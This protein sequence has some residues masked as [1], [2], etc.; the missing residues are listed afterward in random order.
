MKR[1]VRIILNNDG[2][3]LQGTQVSE[4]INGTILNH[5]TTDTQK[6]GKKVFIPW[7]SIKYMIIEPWDV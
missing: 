1:K 3:Q 7:S 5:V 2:T 6:I 4:T